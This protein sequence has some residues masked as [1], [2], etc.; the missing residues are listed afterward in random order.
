MVHEFRERRMNETVLKR[1]AKGPP[2]RRS[3]DEGVTPPPGAT[4]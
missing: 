4:H 3:R 2:E 1:S